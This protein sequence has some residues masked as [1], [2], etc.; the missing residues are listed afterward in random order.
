MSD[1]NE[2]NKP[3]S[4]DDLPVRMFN[5]TFY[6]DHQLLESLT[7]PVEV[8]QIVCAHIRDTLERELMGVVDEELSNAAQNV[9]ASVSSKGPS[10][11]FSEAFVAFMSLLAKR[12]EE[13][14]NVLL[15]IIGGDM[16]DKYPIVDKP[17]WG[18]PPL[19]KL[20]VFIDRGAG[21]SNGVLPAEVG[22]VY[23][24]LELSD[25]PNLSP[26]TK[27]KRAAISARLDKDTAEM[28]AD[29]ASNLTI[30]PD[31]LVGTARFELPYGMSKQPP[32]QEE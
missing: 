7:I 2:M 9:C 25:T 8:Q 24:P 10:T 23:Q 3:E 6:L 26:E 30:N 15:S 27:R 14:A 32:T 16:V 20:Q 17:Q 31:L 5:P 12:T 29:M 13:M 4:C 11:R 28:I 1:Q 18:T 19:S 21:E 22:D